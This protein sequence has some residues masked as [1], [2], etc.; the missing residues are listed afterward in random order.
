MSWTASPYANG[1]GI[2]TPVPARPTA[3]CPADQKQLRSRDAEMESGTRREATNTSKSTGIRRQLPR[4]AGCAGLES[5]TAQA[6][7][8]LRRATRGGLAVLLMDPVL[9]PT[10]NGR[11]FNRR[12]DAIERCPHRGL[13]PPAPYTYLCRMVDNVVRSL[14]LVCDDPGRWR[15]IGRSAALVAPALPGSDGPGRSRSPPPPSPDSA[16]AD[17]H[18]HSCF[19]V[20]RSPARL[21]GAVETGPD[22]LARRG[23]GRRSY[24][25]IPGNVSPTRSP[26]CGRA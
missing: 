1:E 17:P 14:R 6:D 9:P 5:T 20:G 23:V 10:A 3:R 2:I 21:A 15:G 25:S 11:G 8:H 12:T 22:A 4:S 18:L 16:H 24:S 13:P 19:Q 26:G 7:D